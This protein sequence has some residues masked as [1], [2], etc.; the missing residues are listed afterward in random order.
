VVDGRGAPPGGAAAAARAARAVSCVRRVHVL[1]APG[2]TLAD[3][4]ELLR[5]GDAGALAWLDGAAAGLR[6]EHV[7]ALVEAVLVGGRAL[8]RG[9]AD[10]GAI[11][12]KLAPWVPWA[13][14][15][16]LVATRAL[17]ARAPRELLASPAAAA[18]LAELAGPEGRETLVL[19]GATRAAAAGPDGPLER[20][21]AGVL[22]AVRG[23]RAGR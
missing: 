17:L 6:P 2:G 11:E 23:A 3:A 15:L 7:G 19:D 21:I 4:A 14:P 9:A 18:A 8:A 22:E 5:S 20:R 1:E 10:D 16:A 13:R 12:N